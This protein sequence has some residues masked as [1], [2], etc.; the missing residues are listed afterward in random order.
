MNEAMTGAEAAPLSILIVDDSAMMRLMIRRALAL[1]APHAQVSEA[2]NGREALA[3]LE[4]RAV[5][6]VFTDINM[7]VMTGPQLLREIDRR[8]WS[9]LRRV[10]ISTDGSE[11]RREEVRDL[12]VLAYI[13]KPFAPEDMLDVLARLQP[14]ADDA[15]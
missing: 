7:P 2:A 10:I 6:A 4:T 12:D 9:R 13:D 14:D 15:H 8:G 1:A 5:D 11:A 3:V